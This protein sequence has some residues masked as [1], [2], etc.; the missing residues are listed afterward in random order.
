VLVKVNGEIFTQKDLEQRQI[1]ALRDKGN[2][3]P[4]PKEIEDITPDL[5]MNAVDEMLIVQHGRELGYHMSDEVFKNY[6]ESIKTENKLNDADF[7]VA[8][9][10]EGLTLDTFRETSEK[11]YIIRQ[12][13][14]REIMGH[15]SLTEE[16]ARQYY[17]K[18][19]DEFLKP[20]T[21]VLREILISVPT[22]TQ[23]AQQV[24][25]ANT[26]EAAKQKIAAIRER[27]INGEDFAKLAAEVSEAPSK[28]NGGL[29]GTV[30]VEEMSTGIREIVDKLKVDEVSATV[31]TPRGY[32]IF[33]IDSRTAAERELFQNVRDQ[34]TQKVGEERL[35]LLTKK[36]LET[37]RSQALI[38]WKR[39]DLKQMYEKRLA[40]K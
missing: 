17:D 29:I 18:H 7:K 9:S 26:D 11:Q 36:Y 37:L 15:M 19:P 22:E 38:E 32:Q 40:V 5:L 2:D 13:Q 34:I 31:R 21:V 33:K 10:Q 16:E 8:L 12:V 28:S 23:S 14:Q 39:D 35:D 27:A 6:V 4:T 20:A 24:F 1:G 3:H 25:R 30:N